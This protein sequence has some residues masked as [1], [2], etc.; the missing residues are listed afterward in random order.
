VKDDFDFTKFE[1]V[2][3]WWKYKCDKKES[4]FAFVEADDKNN[5]IKLQQ[6][7]TGGM[8]WMVFRKVPGGVLWL[9]LDD[10]VPV[11]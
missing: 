2:I 8:F 3:E 7:L 6:R 10:L 11:D 5:R 4:Y 9:P 1:D